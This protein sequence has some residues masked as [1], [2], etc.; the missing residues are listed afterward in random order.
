MRKPEGPTKGHPAVHY[1]NIITRYKDFA[2]MRE[3][4]LQGYCKIANLPVIAKNVD[5]IETPED[6][7]FTFE[8]LEDCLRNQGDN[9]IF[10]EKIIKTKKL[11]TKQISKFT[12][13]GKKELG[14]NKAFKGKFK[15][16]NGIHD[17]VPELIKP[18]I[19]ARYGAFEIERA[20]RGEIKKEIEGQWVLDNTIDGDAGTHYKVKMPTQPA[21]MLLHW[22]DYSFDRGKFVKLSYMYKQLYKIQSTNVKFSTKDMQKIQVIWTIASH[23]SPVF[24]AFPLN[25]IKKAGYNRGGSAALAS[26]SAFAPRP[27]MWQKATPADIFRYTD[28]IKPTIAFD[29]NTFSSGDE[30]TKEAI[31]DIFDGSFAKGLFIPRLNKE[32]KIKG[33]DAY[34]PRIATDTQSTFSRYSTE[35]RAIWCTLED[36]PKM[37]SKSISAL[38]EENSRLIQLMYN[39]YEKYAVRVHKN[40]SNYY[41][42]GAE[43]RV[44]QTFMP[45][46]AVAV[47][48]E[49]EGISGIIDVVEREALR[50]YGYSVTVRNEEDPVRRIFSSTLQ[51]IRRE[52]E[53][54][55]T[56]GNS[57][58]PKGTWVHTASSVDGIHYYIRLSELKN[59]VGEELSSLNQRDTTSSSKGSEKKY[60]RWY[61]VDEDV[62][63]LLGRPFTNLLKS[64]LS[65]FVQHDANRHLQ[66]LF[67]DKNYHDLLN[68]LETLSGSYGDRSEMRVTRKVT[69]N[70]ETVDNDKNQNNNRRKK[71]EN[72]EYMGHHS[73]DPFA[74]ELVSGKCDK[75]AES[76]SFKQAFD[77]FGEYVTTPRDQEESNRS[78]LEQGIQPT[79]WKGKKPHGFTVSDTPVTNGETHLRYLCK[80]NQAL[81]STNYASVVEWIKETLR[82]KNRPLGVKELYDLST[83]PD[84]KIA[85]LHQVLERTNLFFEKNSEGKYTLRGGSA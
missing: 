33:Y 32:M 74:F 82:H 22:P 42:D 2:D 3:D 64:N 24:E 48:L 6:I 49:R 4:C 75:D 15:L 18:A 14:Y 67:N 69:C 73:I 56:A 26:I 47:Q 44:N 50:M 30:R 78:L 5:L 71:K 54:A 11:V 65:D 20:V 27:V 13:R 10:R 57:T 12:E 72:L 45:I 35:S 17:F 46:I 81:E 36:A 1:K 40:Y 53:R 63:P 28:D 34:G 83:N 38:A 51:I 29:E 76:I 85:Y 60:R 80:D 31:V 23:F 39:C 77:G 21:E 84:L 9:R 55:K 68:L 61:R 59:L 41:L 19:L 62:K 43:G 70:A 58:S 37:R 8:Y 7:A 25:I 66:L 16:V 52:F 79:T